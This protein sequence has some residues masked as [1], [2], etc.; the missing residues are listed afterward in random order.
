MTLLRVDPRAPDP[1]AIEKAATLLCSGGLVA[2]PTET[3]YGLGVNALDARAVERLYRVKGRPAVNPLIVHVA[4]VEAARALVTTWPPAAERL[5]AAFWPGP[6]TLVLTKRAFVPDVVTAGLPAV[7]VRIPAHP[8]ALALLRAARLPIAAPSANRST[9][10]S[11]TRAEH[12][13]KSLG[14][15]VDLVLD[16]GACDV[17]IESAVIDLTGPRP[18]LLRPGALS[19]ERIAGVAGELDLPSHD[20]AANAPRASPG[21]MEL[22]YAPRAPL[23]VVPATNTDAVARAR[24]LARDTRLRGGRVALLSLGKLALDADL[25][26][27]LDAHDA[28]AAARA[29]YDALHAFD[30]AHATLILVEEP[31]ATPAW[32]GVRD[33][34][35]RASAPRA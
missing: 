29:L 22:H 11:P 3:V 1:G 26:R 23:V 18:R 28:E 2:F 30:D 32:L 15:D 5:A 31:P 16:A 17:G 27:T 4:D 34:L 19:P 21:M 20:P 33:R 8:V 6:V 14:P 35:R 10:L 12:V 13:V 25:T 24:E 9:E 7:G